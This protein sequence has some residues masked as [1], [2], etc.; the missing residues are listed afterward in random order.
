[1]RLTGISGVTQH[2]EDDP[3]YG[4]FEVGDLVHV[5][6][7]IAMKQGMGYETHIKIQ[8]QTGLVTKVEAT[9]LF[10]QFPAFGAY[11]VLR[12]YAERISPAKESDV[13]PPGV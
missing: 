8:D 4:Y 12:R 6:Y 13:K 3:D 10:V 7:S 1:M 2:V 11:W 5:P 9:R